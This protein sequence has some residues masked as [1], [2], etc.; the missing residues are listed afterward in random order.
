MSTVP[1]PRLL[2]DRIEYWADHRPDDEAVRY[3]GTSYTW[4]QWRDRIRRVSGALR[5]AGIGPGDVVG[6]LDKNTPSCL[7]VL[8]GASAIG[9][10]TAIPNWRLAAGEL[11]YVI[12]DSGASVLFAGPDFLPAVEAIRDKLPKVR[13]IVTVG[14]AADEYEALLS[15][16]EPL[17]PRD[18][19]SADDLALLIYSSGTTGFPKGVMISHRNLN[20]HSE[21]IRDIFAF[22]PGDINL[23]AM[24]L[25]HVGGTAY[26]LIGM[27]QGAMSIMTREPDAA[28]LFGAVA[29]GATH[30]FLVPAV[31]AG[32]VGAGEQAIAA[33]SGLKHIGYGAS[34]CPLPLL[35]AALAAWPEA[36]FIQVYGQTEAS[37][38]SHSLGPDAHR[39]ESH[40]E[41]LSSC[42]TPLP[43]VEARVVDPATGEDLAPGDPG[44]I[45]LRAPSVM[46]G[47]HNNA[48]ATAET[49]TT[50]GWLRTGDVGRVDE[51][52]FYFI[53]DRVKDMIISG[54]E[55][56]YSPEVERV[57]ADHPAVAEV[58]V[59]GV[60]D[61][62]WGEVVK[63]VVVLRPGAQLGIEELTAFCRER[64][65]AFKC[66]SSVDVVDALPRNPTGK[67]LKKDLRKPYWQDRT[68]DVH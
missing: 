13:R 43:G 55:N 19:V 45:W 21:Q 22:G 12:D 64:L 6:F 3:G 1:E 38:V 48:E 65:A 33:M 32:L 50:D 67:I 23:V 54:G 53:V 16:A 27:Y 9:A 62:R 51:D 40:L 18:D 7:E 47:Y 29:G 15:A 35:Q 25:F 60:P 28:S 57:V 52:G 4:S 46:L 49:I 68:S 24:P 26:A 14:G 34:P 36:D 11:A 8:F 66:P 39:D 37:G 63:A 30:A 61:E 56:I 41:R 42:G 17:A 5:A 59:I 58:A 2:S 20:A 44:E 31:I 10:A